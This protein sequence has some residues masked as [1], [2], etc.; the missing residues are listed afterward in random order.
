M[1]E[2]WA[3]VEVAVPV[4]TAPAAS[5]ESVWPMLGSLTSPS[6]SQP[7]AVEDGQAGGVSE[8]V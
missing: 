6:T 2:L 1:L 4:T 5:V 3:A 8:G 7:P